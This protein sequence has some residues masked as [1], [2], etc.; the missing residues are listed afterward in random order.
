MDLPFFHA[1]FTQKGILNLNALTTPIKKSTLLG[2]DVIERDLVDV[3]GAR[4]GSERISDKP[5]VDNKKKLVSKGTSVRTGFSCFGFKIA[6]ICKLDKIVVC[7]GFADG[8]RIA[9]ALQCGVACCVG[10][11]NLINIADSISE[12]APHLKILVIAD[13]DLTGY[14]VL[15]KAG[16]RY[17][18]ARTWSLKDASD[19]YQE[20][21]LD[22]LRNE[23]LKPLI[24][25]PIIDP[26]FKK[27][28]FIPA[29][30]ESLRKLVSV[31]A[32]SDDHLHAASVARAIA[33][34]VRHQVPWFYSE[35][36]LM[37]LI[38]TKAKPGIINY[39]T[40]NIIMRTD[41]TPFV[42]SVKQN[43]E[44]ITQLSKKCLRRHTVREVSPGYELSSIDFD[45]F[46]VI[47]LPW[48]MGS[49]KTQRGGRPFV[50]YAKANQGAF[51]TTCH[52]QSLI[53]ELAS[54]LSSDNAKVM[55][56][57]DVMT[58]I[59]GIVESAAICSPSLTKA[60]FKPLIDK[61]EYLF[62]DEVEQVIRFLQSSK[63]CSTEEGTSKDVYDALRL[64]IRNAKK[65]VVADAHLSDRAIRFIENARA[66]DNPDYHED[67][68]I[69][70]MPYKSD[71]NVSL[72]VE[73]KGTVYGEI[74]AQLYDEKKLWICCDSKKRVLE[75]EEFISK[76]CPDLNILTVT[77][78]NKGG[79]NGD[80]KQK[81]FL[82][83]PEFESYKY[84]VVIHSPVISSG[85]SIQHDNQPH[86]NHCFVFCS[87]AS[88]TSSDVAQM[89]RRVRYLK[90]FTVSIAKS[91]KN[92]IDDALSILRGL[93]ESA[94]AD[95]LSKNYSDF[96]EI[97]ADVRADDALLKNHFA[98]S[99]YY[100]LKHDGANIFTVKESQKNES[101]DEL[102][103]FAKAAAE[104]NVLDRIVDAQDIDNNQC[105]DLESLEYRT[106]EQSYQVLKHRVKK[107]LG[108]PENQ[109][110]NEED[111]ETWDSGFIVSR[112]DRYS[113]AFRGVS[114]DIDDKQEDE[115]S[116]R[117]YQKARINAYK[118]IF[119]GYRLNSDS[120]VIDD[121][122]SKKILDKVIE[123][124]FLLASLKLVAAKYA[125]WSDSKPFK[126]PSNAKSEVKKIFERMGL[127]FG[128]RQKCR[129]RG[130]IY[131]IDSESKELISNLSHRRNES[132]KT[133]VRDEALALSEQLSI[134]KQKVKSNS[135]KEA[136]SC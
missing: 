34:K 108:I 85:L 74:I 133:K 91:N 31:L 45:S 17:Q 105:R 10:E 114:A 23:L 40:I 35:R 80:D 69:L 62:I 43:I 90:D 58:E 61:C 129:K 79:E 122:T 24:V 125:D 103:K 89:M 57:N 94:R 55:H 100:Q 99:L 54:R 60:N 4:V 27:Y 78:D 19:V 130:N 77:A 86:F 8:L 134:V 13:N 84:D 15:D 127:E 21:G 132:R 110:I 101:V 42:R 12:Y 121:K 14:S 104:Q 41:V 65:I 131:K 49:G 18:V 16:D 97:V 135:H 67:F 111:V 116:L 109:G 28:Q 81:S 68:L 36:E 126:R 92:D 88:V 93:E 22:A 107:D 95:G 30:G 25:A 117:S 106:Q 102:A 75:L 38:Y 50:E 82:T 118:K 39:E 120:F 47:C 115:L 70:T 98:N 37:S 29:D 76:Q 26:A 56:Y 128:K 73:D 124:R 5:I 64:I 83:D 1:Y 33:F 11:S 53:D 44:R 59:K 123:H 3:V 51:I 2:H 119:N 136:K 20:N 6:D 96:D 7:A 63:M 113:A 48:G 72:Q 46:D 112:L 32:K 52:R 66:G 9:Q 71:I 87:G